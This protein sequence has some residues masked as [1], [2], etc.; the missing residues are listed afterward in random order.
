MEPE[1]MLKGSKS[2][3]AYD[4]RDQHR[5]HDGVDGIAAPPAFFCHRPCVLVQLLSF[6]PG[7]TRPRRSSRITAS[8]NPHCQA[9]LQPVEPGSPGRGGSAEMMT[10]ACAMGVVVG[11]GEVDLR[12][13]CRA[14]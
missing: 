14:G 9:T 3:G 1:G 11:Q 2:E 7:A 10:I 4:E 8:R 13:P 5:V 6:I 12:R